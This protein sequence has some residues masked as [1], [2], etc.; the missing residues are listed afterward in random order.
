MQLHLP[1]SGTWFDV[2]SSYRWVYWLLA[3]SLLSLLCCTYFECLNLLL[4]K[5]MCFPVSYHWTI[6]RAITA[7]TAEALTLASVFYRL[8]ALARLGERWH[9]SVCRLFVGL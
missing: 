2:R 5:L 4:H 3:S 8:I 1:A 9:P 7:E 6:S